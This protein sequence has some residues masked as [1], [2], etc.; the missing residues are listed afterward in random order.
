MIKIDKAP[1]VAKKAARSTPAAQTDPIEAPMAAM[2]P[3]I[4]RE[5]STENLTINTSRTRM[6]LIAQAKEAKS[7]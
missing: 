3:K 2:T 7:S 6:T 1:G 5:A 4:K